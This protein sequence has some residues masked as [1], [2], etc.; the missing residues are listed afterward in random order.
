MVAVRLAV[1][2]RAGQ[3]YLILL[4]VMYRSPATTVASL[5]LVALAGCGAD[6]PAPQA[7]AASV[8]ASTS[9][10][11]P[12]D[13]SLTVKAVLNADGAVS[14]HATSNLPDGTELLGTV[15][16]APTGSPS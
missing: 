15:A 16:Q 1:R 3:K 4:S 10:A 2:L 7:P 5:L 8:Q 9:T 11:A 13:V 12:I 6:S 14:V